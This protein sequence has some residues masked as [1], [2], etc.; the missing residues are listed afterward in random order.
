MAHVR[1]KFHDI[2]KLIK[3]TDSNDRENIISHNAFNKINRI[4]LIEKRIRIE[5]MEERKK[6]IALKR[7][8]E[9]R[10]KERVEKERALMDKE[11]KET[12]HKIRQEKEIIRK[13]KY[14]A[15]KRLMAKKKEAMEIEKNYRERRVQLNNS[16]Q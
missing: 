6:R 7:L 11:D 2:A 14:E 12:K 8:E 15:H 4:Y 10:E 1:R 5:K 16:V 13:E 3:V 9:Q